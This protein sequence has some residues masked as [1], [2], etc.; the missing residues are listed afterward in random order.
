ME[1]ALAREGLTATRATCDL[2]VKLRLSAIRG[3]S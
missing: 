3:V 1:S 2:F